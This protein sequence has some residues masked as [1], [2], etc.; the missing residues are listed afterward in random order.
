MNLY[1]VLS[2]F[3]ES[4]NLVQ[5]LFFII[6]ANEELNV[7][8]AKRTKINKVENHKANVKNVSHICFTDSSCRWRSHRV[9]NFINLESSSAG[10]KLLLALV[11][12]R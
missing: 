2:L 10:T 7:V 9:S 3:H 5:S 8:P 11:R 12:D 6:N 4:V 1:D